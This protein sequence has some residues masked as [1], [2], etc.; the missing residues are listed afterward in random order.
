MQN[1]IILV[2]TGHILE[3]SVKEVEEVIDREEPDVIAV[4]LCEGRFRALKGD[5]EDFSIK[6]VIS[7]GSPF[8]LL[9]HWL[10]AYVQRKMGAE[11]GI[12]PGADMMA[13]IKKAEERG[14]EIAL[15]DRPIQVTMQRFWSAMKFTEKIKMLFSIFFAVGLSLIHI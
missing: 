1:N 6:D 9:T 15:I 2:G 4:E 12:E 10:L 14:C 11:L 3:K 7:G 8:L 13:A 5:M